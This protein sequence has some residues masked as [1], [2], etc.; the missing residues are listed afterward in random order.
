MATRLTTRR[1]AWLWW[2]LQERRRSRTQSG[3]VGS[4]RASESGEERLTE[5]GQARQ[6]EA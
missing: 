2:W 5:D 4:P 1:R 6:I 3:A